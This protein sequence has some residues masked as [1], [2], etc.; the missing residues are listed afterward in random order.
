[1]TWLQNLK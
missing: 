1:V